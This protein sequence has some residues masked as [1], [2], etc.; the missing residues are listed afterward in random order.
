[1]APRRDS[2]LS[3]F[4]GGARSRSVLAPRQSVPASR[5]VG[6]AREGSGQ[7]PDAPLRSDRG[8]EGLGF[9]LWHELAS[10]F[11]HEV[12]PG[13][14]ERVS[15]F[16]PEDMYSNALG[17]RLGA[18]V[19]REGGLLSRANYDALTEA[20]L[21]S[22][23]GLLVPLDVQSARATM[24]QLDGRWW[25]SKRSLPDVRLVTRRAM[26]TGL[27]LQPWR[28][29]DAFAP[30]ASPPPPAACAERPPALQLTVPD[31]LGDFVISQAVEVIWKPGP[32]K[33]SGI[34]WPSSQKKEIRAEDLPQLIS[35][36]HD[37]L[38]ATLGK[39]FERPR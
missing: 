7:W 33:G 12:L 13:Y 28:L 25:T 2:G 23:L 31:R 1:M 14:S 8:R 19:A 18:A 4:P 22:M 30:G 10:W 29:E 20:W 9:A 3:G 39:G 38:E 11:G 32:W 15:T 37:E 5:G 17:I 21:G 34:P 36:V 27:V 24:T 16:S 6:E 26:P 35:V